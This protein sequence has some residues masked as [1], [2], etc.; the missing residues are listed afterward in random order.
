VSI[1]K[2]IDRNVLLQK[3]L[4][5]LESLGILDEQML[6]DRMLVADRGSPRNG[7]MMIAQAWTDPDFKSRMMKDGRIVADEMGI[8]APWAGPLGVL[9]DTPDVHH[10]I[11][12][13]LCS[14]YP[15]WLLGYPP[16]WYKSS[17]YRSRAVRE[18]RQ[19]LKEWGQELSDDV[20]IR[21]VDS[22]ADYR[23]LV[24][25]MRPAGTEHWTVEQL[26]DLVTPDVL[27]GAEIL[28]DYP[29]LK[30]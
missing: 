28:H 12:C 26:A 17:T 22:T 21:V 10:L 29:T 16:D 6:Q 24:M 4:T 13:T 2:G 1:P 20:L 23:W 11:V 15:R 9:E 25:P 27:V 30:S 7:A 3:V 14:C 8:L 18:P 19:L 5:K